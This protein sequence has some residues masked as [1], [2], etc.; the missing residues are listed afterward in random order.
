MKLSHRSRVVYNVLQDLMADHGIKCVIGILDFLD[1]D[2]CFL[3]S[4]D[5]I[6]HDIARCS[7]LV[8]R[9]KAALRT[10]MQDFGAIDPVRMLLRQ[11]MMLP[12]PLN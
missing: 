7:R 12:V 2:L 11:Q 10:K 9:Y 5:R 8:F 3:T 6:R 4:R 1:I